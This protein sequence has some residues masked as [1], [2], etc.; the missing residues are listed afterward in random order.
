MAYA[1][2]IASLANSL[3]GL[4]DWDPEQEERIRGLAI[5]IAVVAFYIL[6][7]SLNGLQASLRVRFP[8]PCVSFRS[9]LIVGGQALIL[10]RSPSSQQNIAN[11][12]HG[13]MTHVANIF[14]YLFGYV[15][16]GSWSAIDWIGGGQFRRLAVLSCAVMIICVSITCYTQEETP[17]RAEGGAAGKGI[18]LGAALRNVRVAIR[19]LPVAVQRVCFGESSPLLCMRGGGA[20]ETSMLTILIS[21]SS[22]LRLVCMVSLPLL[23]VSPLRLSSTSSNEC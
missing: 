4:G 20:Q 6:D 3:G 17:K 10:D 7:F 19:V 15:N 14:G 2:A 13:R 5:A 8:S 1:R 22:I 11:A 23:H 18:G 16:L 9:S 21:N 12:W